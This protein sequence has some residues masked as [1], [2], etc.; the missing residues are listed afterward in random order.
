MDVDVIRIL[1]VTTRTTPYFIK[2]CSK[3]HKTQ[4]VALALSGILVQSMLLFAH[5]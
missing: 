1:W 5:V 3:L 2:A 4:A